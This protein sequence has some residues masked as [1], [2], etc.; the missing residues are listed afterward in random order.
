[1]VWIAPPWGEGEWLTGQPM[2][3][4]DPVGQKGAETDGGVERIAKTA[5]GCAGDRQGVHHS[6]H[7]EGTA[8]T[9]GCADLDPQCSL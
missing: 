9:A 5:G 7:S 4:R 8:G 6:E 2:P 3:A 1:M